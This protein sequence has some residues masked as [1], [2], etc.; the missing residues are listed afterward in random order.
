MKFQIN[1]VDFEW[2]ASRHFGVDAPWQW[3]NNGVPGMWRLSTDDNKIQCLQGH[4]YLGFVNS[5]EK[6]QSPSCR[7]VLS[8]A[9]VLQSERQTDS[10]YYWVSTSSMV[11]CHN[12]ILISWSSL[13][14]NLYHIHSMYGNVNSNEW[15]WNCCKTSSDNEWIWFTQVTYTCMQII[16]SKVLYFY[17]KC[18]ARFQEM[19]LACLTIMTERLLKAISDKWIWNCC[20]TFSDNEWNLIFTG[21]IHNDMYANY[22]IKSINT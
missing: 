11:D 7:K 16:A 22:C 3:H 13:Q 4:V 15:I 6:F 8:I 1:I 5:Q 20:K 19:T 2:F 21:N 12:R 9:K 14:S 10:D 18:T 17:Y